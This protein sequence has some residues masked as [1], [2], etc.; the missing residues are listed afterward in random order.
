MCC[1]RLCSYVDHW[2][3]LQGSLY[4]EPY[5]SLRWYKPKCGWNIRNPIM[6]TIE[7]KTIITIGKCGVQMESKHQRSWV[8]GCQNTCCCI[9]WK[10]KLQGP[11]FNLPDWDMYFY[12][13]IF[14]S[15]YNLYSRKPEPEKTWASLVYQT[16]SEKFKGILRSCIRWT[17]A[18]RTRMGNNFTDLLCGWIL[19]LR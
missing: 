7:F 6:L 9:S 2:T 8:R 13:K 4:T 16:R 3:F 11:W 12:M 18:F 14:P 17:R 10:H 5:C 15:G 19:S 1:K